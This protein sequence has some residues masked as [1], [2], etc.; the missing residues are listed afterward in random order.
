[1]EKSAHS[2]SAI[3]VKYSHWKY[4][5]DTIALICFYSGRDFTYDGDRKVRYSLFQPP[6][7]LQPECV[8]HSGSEGLQGNLLR[9]GEG[10]G[11]RI[12]HKV[13]ERCLTPYSAGWEDVMISGAVA[14][15][16]ITMSHNITVT[17]KTVNLKGGK[18][19]SPNWFQWATELLHSPH[20][21]I[22]SNSFL[23][24]KSLEVWISC[25]T[26]QPKAT[27]L[28]MNQAM[29]LGQSVK[30]SNSNKQGHFACY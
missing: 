15:T 1:M 6:L 4:M 16:L 10:G 29:H 14:A 25:Y 11:W 23:L 22:E 8:T 19:L 27:Y 28:L 17:L 3:V 20:Y 26:K 7:Q 13:P 9:G 12:E 21:Y 5:Q 30:L 2:H 18:S 24:L